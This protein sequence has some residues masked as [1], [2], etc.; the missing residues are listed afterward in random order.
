[1]SVRVLV[2]D[3]HVLFRDGVVSLLQA[4]GYQVVGQAGNG[5]EAVEMARD[6]RP[7]LVLLDLSMP[8]LTGLEAL[9][10]IRQEAPASRV[11]I[12]TVSDEDRDLF[13]AIRLGARG[14]LLKSL[15]TK[16][17]LS[18]LG[19]LQRGEMALSRQAAT[20]LIE[21]MLALQE[22]PGDAA[23]A[24][25]KEILTAREIELLQLVADGLSNKA[26]ARRLNVS[27]NTVKYHLR[28]ILQKLGVQNR[29]EAVTYALQAGLIQ[30]AA[31]RN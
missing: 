18:S 12:L 11:V 15:D 3:D 24:P 10:R 8:G 9:A 17:F 30:L 2:A 25:R 16:A 14:Y 13:D 26:A 20:R 29:T 31:P 19:G 1:M 7:E 21:G 6:L 27:E 4:A 22:T 28:Q 5:F 23:P